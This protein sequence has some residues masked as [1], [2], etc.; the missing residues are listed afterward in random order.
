M[1]KEK[2]REMESERE[3]QIRWESVRE[4]EGEKE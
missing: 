1:E 4:E 2:K 3:R